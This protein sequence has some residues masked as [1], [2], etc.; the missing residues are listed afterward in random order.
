MNNNVASEDGNSEDQREKTE[1]IEGVSEV[2]E[3]DQ[4]KIKKKD[5]PPWRL[6]TWISS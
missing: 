1:N 4:N 3:G 6:P 2:V 5:P